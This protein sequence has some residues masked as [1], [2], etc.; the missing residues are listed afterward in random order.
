M[1]P[2][3]LLCDGLLFSIVAFILL[4]WWALAQHRKL[5]DA[6]VQRGKDDYMQRATEARQHHERQMRA[7]E[8]RAIK[9]AK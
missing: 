4:T 3:D 1:N 9:A 2:Q 5:L 6:Q 8:L 7:L